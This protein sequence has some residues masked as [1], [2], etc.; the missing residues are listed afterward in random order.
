[1]LRLSDVRDAIT[2]EVRD[3]FMTSLMNESCSPHF[4]FEVRGNFAEN[5]ISG[6]L[7]KVADLCKM[8]KAMVSLRGSRLSI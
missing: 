8:S 7:Y 5:S 1:M 6:K 2:V 4:I 3:Y